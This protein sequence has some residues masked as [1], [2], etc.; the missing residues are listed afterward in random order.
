MMKDAIHVWEQDGKVSAMIDGIPCAAVGDTVGEAIR[1]LA[2]GLGDFVKGHAKMIENQRSMMRNHA[3]SLLDCADPSPPQECTGDRNFVQRK[4]E[5]PDVVS[6][7]RDD[8]D[9]KGI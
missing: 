3:R 5:N 7:Y 8:P 2:L 6:P 4:K 1:S 9:P